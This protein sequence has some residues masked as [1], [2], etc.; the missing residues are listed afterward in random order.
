[1][2]KVYVQTTREQPLDPTTPAKAR[3]LV[4]A[5]RAK[6]VTRTPFTIRL[7]DR[8]MGYTTDV[9]SEV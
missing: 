9:L 3:L 1:M 6:V 7:R 5:G 4:T 8:E 2:M